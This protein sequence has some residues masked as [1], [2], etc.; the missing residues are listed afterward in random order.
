MQ[1]WQNPGGGLIKMKLLCKSQTFRLEKGVFRRE[2][3]TQYRNARW[4]QLD[5]ERGFVW[6]GPEDKIV[7]L[8]ARI[9]N[10]FNRDNVICW[11]PLTQRFDYSR[12]ISVFKFAVLERT[13][14]RI[15][16]NLRIY[17]EH[18]R[19]DYWY[20]RSLKCKIAVRSI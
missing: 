12:Q 19:R 14:W 9:F 17:Y 3:Q 1:I 6:R 10:I 16:K 2:Q 7:N 4:E 11:C 20:S 18:V 8:T 5:T 15:L 13:G